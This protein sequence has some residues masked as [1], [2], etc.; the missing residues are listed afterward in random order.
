M[1]PKPGNGTVPSVRQ[2][3]AQARAEE[4]AGR[5]DRAIAVLQEAAERGPDDW[6][7]LRMLADLL[8]RTGQHRAANE[9]YR[10][11][12]QNYELDGLDTQAIAAW[13]RI[14][15][16]EPGLATVH[17]KLGELYARAGLRADSRRHY[18][19][20]LERYR[21]DAHAREVAQIEARLALLDAGPAAGPVAPAVPPLSPEQAAGREE[22]EAADAEFVKESLAEARL[23]RRYGLELQARARLDAL[24]SRF[25]DHAEARRELADLQHEAGPTGDQR[26][27]AGPPATPPAAPDTPPPPSA[28]PPPAP[29]AAPAAPEPPA[30]DDVGHPVDSDDYATRFDLG[31]ACLQMGLL[32]EAIAELRLAA[33]D[34]ARLVECASLLAECFVEQGQPERAVRWLEKGLA[35]PGLRAPR[36]RGLQYELGAAYEACGEPSHALAVYARLQSEDAGFR[37]VQERVRRLSKSADREGEAE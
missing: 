3:R 33:A 8:T 27:E 28:T 32:D 21:E 20:A 13:K 26:L 23:F 22:R 30:G 7:N 16:N 24:L 15:S 37:D 19:A 18:E 36:R 17:L 5:I 35:A 11:L 29:E 14:L 1:D 31:V 34:P 2:V 9:H 6:T 10:R 4:R 25:P 12:A